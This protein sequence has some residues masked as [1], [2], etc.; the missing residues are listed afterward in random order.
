MNHQIHGL[1]WYALYTRPNFEKKTYVELER[2]NIESFLPLH[3]VTHRWSDRKKIL[4]VPLFPNYIFVRI[5]YRRRWDLLKINGLVKF[6]T[7][8]NT[9]EVIPDQEMENIK[10]L[11]HGDPEVSNENYM[12]GEELKIINGPLAGLKG[13]L[14]NDGE[15][16]LAV[17]VN[18]LRQYVIVKA[19]PADLERVNEPTC[20]V[21]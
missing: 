17:R 7:C 20:S 3:K 19:S 15:Q 13:V 18:I 2:K 11:I 10:K 12:R 1:N 8:G 4:E 16:K 5:D 14:I 9:A 6:L 21:N